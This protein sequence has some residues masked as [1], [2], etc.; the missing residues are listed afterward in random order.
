VWKESGQ[1]LMEFQGISRG[2]RPCTD[3]LFSLILGK[4]FNMDPE[5]TSERTAFQE[6]RYSVFY[7]VLTIILALLFI[8]MALL[9]LRSGW[10]GSFSVFQIIL[11]SLLLALGI[12]V[13]YAGITLRTRRYFRLDLSHKILQVYG[14]IGPTSRKIP[15]DRIYLENEDFFIEKDGRRRKLQIMK[16][17]CDKGD[18][19]ALIKALEA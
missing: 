8:A 17:A 7:M 1:D 4:T 3:L 19:Q 10:G 11:L 9:K 16:Y 6:V 13:L 15:F 14:V 18:L 12:L 5:Q 2:T